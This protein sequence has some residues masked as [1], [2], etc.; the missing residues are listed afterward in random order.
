PR[1]PARF[2]CPCTAG[3]S[4]AIDSSDNPIPIPLSSSARVGGR[5]RVP[6]PCRVLCGMGGISGSYPSN[7]TS[8]ICPLDNLGQPSRPPYFV[9]RDHPIAQQNL[10]NLRLLHLV[11]RIDV[12]KYEFQVCPANLLSNRIPRQIL[13]HQTR[14]RNN[15]RP[16]RQLAHLRRRRP[17][18]IALDSQKL[19]RQ[20]ER[21]RDDPQ[22]KFL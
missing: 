15:R 14:R 9:H 20:I 5:W 16:E 6:H 13:G 11:L 7:L 4:I 12:G 17:V 2:G 8:N 22:E 18:H 3:I 21:I 10:V 1:K 19:R